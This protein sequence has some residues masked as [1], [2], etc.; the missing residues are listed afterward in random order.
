MQGGSKKKSLAYY[1][2]ANVNPEIFFD[3]LSKS[4]RDLAG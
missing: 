4:K 2:K 1:Q 3:L